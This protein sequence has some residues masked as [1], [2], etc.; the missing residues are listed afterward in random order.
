MSLTYSFETAK[1]LLE[2]LRREANGLTEEVTG[3]KFFNFVIT[4]YHIT[5]WIKSDPS[6]PASAKNDIGS[7]YQNTYVAICRDLANSS[8]HFSLLANY[9]NRVTDSAESEQGF[10]CG[11]FGFGGFGVGEEQ[12]DIECTDGSKYNTLELAQNVLNSWESFFDRHGI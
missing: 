2:K 11:R 6:V 5:D 7:M 10:G 3:D 9:P 4:A 12:I 1:D 8:K